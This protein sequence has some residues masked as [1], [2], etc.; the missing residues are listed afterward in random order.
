MSLTELMRFFTVIITSPAQPVTK[1][2]LH[3]LLFDDKIRNSPQTSLLLTLFIS[4]S[5][6]LALFQFFTVAGR[7]K[8]LQI[9]MPTVKK[10]FKCAHKQL[11]IHWRLETGDR[12]CKR[13]NL[14]K[15]LSKNMPGTIFNAKIKREKKS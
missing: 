2:T 4:F 14:T 6:F 3:S 10:S 12:E 11:L 15:N 8:Q 9:H 13:V 1:H 5:L 7:F